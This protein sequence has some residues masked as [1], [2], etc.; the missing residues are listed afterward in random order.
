MYSKP[1]YLVIDLKT[2][3]LE[4]LS[5]HLSLNISYSALLKIILKGFM[6]QYSDTFGNWVLTYYFF[7]V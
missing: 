7:Y 5:Y 2:K 6:T 1:A 4:C 3:P